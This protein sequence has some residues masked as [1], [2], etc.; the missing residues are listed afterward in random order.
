M[1]DL[2]SFIGKMALLSIGFVLVIT[3]IGTVNASGLANNSLFDF[4]SPFKGGGSAGMLVLLAG[5]LPMIAIVM[6]LLMD[7]V[8]NDMIVVR[9]KKKRKLFYE[10][11]FFAV[12]LTVFLTSLIIVIGVVGSLIS[13]GQ[14]TNLWGTKEGSL[15]F[16]LDNKD[17]FQLYVPRVT[18]GK[19][20]SYI[21]GSRFLVILFMI[22]MVIFL[23]LL[24]RK[25]V[26]VF[27]TSLILWLGDGLFFDQ[28]SLF[29]GQA[30]ISME[31]WLSPE[32]QLFNLIYFLLWIT[33]LFFICLKIYDKKEFLS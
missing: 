7:Q 8:E 22:L 15:Y 27:F 10:H 20:W 9:I 33:V 14:L 28:Y 4:L 13:T 30:R 18:S 29:T 17:Y 12:G 21:I 6:P 26:Y 23:K 2:K 31:L 25:N 32:D 24:L 19:V 3:V 1:L 5:I 16:W 11:V